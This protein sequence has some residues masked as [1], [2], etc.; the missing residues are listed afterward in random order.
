MLL[1]GLI[2]EW[3]PPIIVSVFFFCIV[4]IIETHSVMYNN[5]HDIKWPVVPHWK[6]VIPY[7]V[8]YTQRVQV[9]YTLLI[10]FVFFLLCIELLYSLLSEAEEQIFASELFFGDNKIQ[11]VTCHIVSTWQRPLNFQTKG[12][13]FAKHVLKKTITIYQD[14]IT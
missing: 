7:L 14:R 2:A 8:L 5:D 9:V 13:L 12:N 6:F 10:S 1:E 3:K 11:N 4:F